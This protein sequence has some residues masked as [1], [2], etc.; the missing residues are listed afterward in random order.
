MKADGPFK[1]DP[2]IR[3]SPTK[4]ILWEDCKKKFHNKL[5]G[6]VEDRDSIHTVTGKAAHSVIE[7]INKGQVL[8]G[9]QRQRAFKNYLI[10][11]CSETGV[12]MRFEPAYEA[13]ND[14]LPH[15][16]VEPGWKLFSAEKKQIVEFDSF[17]F[18]YLVDAIFIN[19]AGTRLRITDYKSAAKAP[20]DALQLRL[21]GWIELIRRPEFQSLQIDIEFHMLRDGKV[22]SQSFDKEAFREMDAYMRRQVALM[23]TL[24]KA[25]YWPETPSNFNCKWCPL[26]N[27]PVRIE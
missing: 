14:Y 10:Q 25:N 20:K 11:Q 3:L 18:S 6:D 22:V 8:N 5:F 23:Y 12:P 21:Y 24:K 17:L 26:T 9:E 19:D 1:D 16:A 4:M 27:C 15:Y 2:R 13:V 7:D